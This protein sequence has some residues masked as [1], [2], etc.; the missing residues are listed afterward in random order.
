MLKAIQYLSVSLSVLG[1]A[2]ARSVFYQL[3]CQVYP[4]LEIVVLACVVYA[5]LTSSL[6]YC[7]VLC[8]GLAL[9]TIWKHQLV[10]NAAAI[11]LE[12]LYWLILC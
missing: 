6:V 1:A 7:N 4:F 2:V 9:N 12:L 8:M 10:H 3:Q 11:V 5:L